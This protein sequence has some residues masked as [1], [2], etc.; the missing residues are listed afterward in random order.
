MASVPLQDLLTIETDG[1]IVPGTQI[2]YTD[3][4]AARVRELSGKQRERLQLVWE[5]LS[6]SE[7][8]AMRDFWHQYRSLPVTVEI[9][10][11]IYSVR[12]VEPV[13]RSYSGAGLHR[14]AAT[15]YGSE[16][17]P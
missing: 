5:C 1:E 10:D 3:D 13:R 17:T 14:I 16:V 7:F 6:D 11:T 15:V 9:G 4:G 12:L 2:D 8:A